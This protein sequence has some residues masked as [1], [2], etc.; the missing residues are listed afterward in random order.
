[1][2]GPADDPPPGGAGVGAGA[3]VGTGAGVG[4]GQPHASGPQAEH[5]DCVQDPAIHP[6]PELE[7]E[8]PWVREHCVAVQQSHT[9]V[10]SRRDARKKST[11]V[12]RL[13]RSKASTGSVSAPHVASNKRSKTGSLAAK[14]MAAGGLG[15]PW[16]DL[17]TYRTQ[18]ACLLGSQ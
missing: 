6:G 12:M 14:R 4:S 7:H 11:L 16:R 17:D 8:A 9:H 15:V 3:G 5:E 2:I 18:A 1:M 13:M 10:A